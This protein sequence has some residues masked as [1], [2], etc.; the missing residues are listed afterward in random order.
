MSLRKLEYIPLLDL[1]CESVRPFLLGLYALDE[2]LVKL[3]CSLHIQARVE[4]T[5]VDS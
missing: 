5:H 4:H 1:E 3:A 2:N